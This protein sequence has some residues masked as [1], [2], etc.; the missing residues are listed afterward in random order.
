MLKT[1]IRAFFLAV[2]AAAMVTS[3]SLAQVWP[4]AGDAPDGVPGRQDTVGVGPL[5]SITGTITRGAGD[6]VDTY[7][8]I[9]TDPAAFLASTKTSFGG[10]AVTSTGGS[11][12]TRLWLWTNSGAPVLANDDINSGSLGTDT[13]GSLVS[14]PSTFPG[15][16]GG[17][18]VAPTA[19]G[20]TLTAGQ[21]YLLSI[22]E[23]ANDPVDGALVPIFDLGSDFD[24]LHGPNPAAG[25]FSG[26]EN[27]ADS[28]AFTYTIALRGATYCVPEPTGIAF[29]LVGA[30]VLVCARR[31]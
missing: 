14:S 13:L 27:G 30:V 8:I 18:I 10:S 2:A 20:V 12:D 16:S 28:T 6:H 1:R 17:E 5:T 4:E 22:S 11:A 21:K 26:W 3:S 29:A 31:R 24:A 9:I 15:L 19:A 7:S 25:A 23:F